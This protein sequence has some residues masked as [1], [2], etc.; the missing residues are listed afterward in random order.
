MGTKTRFEREA[1]GNLE[2]VHSTGS[3]QANQQNLLVNLALDLAH[4]F[5]YR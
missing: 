5:H 3:Q 4:L 1:E 2:M